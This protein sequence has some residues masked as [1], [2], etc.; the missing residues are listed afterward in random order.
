MYFP[1]VSIIKKSPFHKRMSKSYYSKCF[2]SIFPFYFPILFSHSIFLFYFS[3]LF[4]YSI[5]LFYLFFYSIFLF[6]FSILS[7]YFDFYSIFLFYHAISISIPIFDSNY[8]FCSF[9]Q[10]F[11]FIL[12]LTSQLVVKEAKVNVLQQEHNF[13][14][15]N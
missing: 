12:N 3:I 6:Y 2:D 8:L 15:S 5:F 14:P 4:F 11:R 10:C 7:C 1:T 9:T 13:S